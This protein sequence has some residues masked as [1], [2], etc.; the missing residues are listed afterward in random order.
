MAACAADQ[1][2]D[3]GYGERAS[4]RRRLRE[5]TGDEEF[6]V[7][8][9]AVVLGVMVGRTELETSWRE[10]RSKIQSNERHIAGFGPGLLQRDR[11]LLVSLARHIA[12]IALPPA[13]TPGRAHA[14]SQ[15]H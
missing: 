2:R 13:G 15:R 1:A 4:V 10:V 14:P 7:V 9:A 11:V 3:I 5:I 12:S 6:Q 8:D